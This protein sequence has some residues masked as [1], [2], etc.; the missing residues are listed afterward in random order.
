MRQ[1]NNAW[2]TANEER[3]RL[4]DRE[5]N[6]QNSEAVAA[7]SRKWNLENPE[8]KAL[9]RQQRRAKIND[10]K[11]YK[12]TAKEIKKLLGN[13]CTY[14]GAQSQHVD[15]VLPLSR[16]GEH[17]IGNLVGACAGCNLSKGAKF[18]TEWRRMLRM[19]E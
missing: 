9:Y 13:P 19:S 12:V 7:K 18:I 16:G 4:Y 3:K 11:A 10:S 15:H 1:L 5:Y 2:R 17:R 8:K 14:C 6:R